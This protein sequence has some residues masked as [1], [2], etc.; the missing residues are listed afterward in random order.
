MQEGQA[1]NV[2]ITLGKLTAKMHEN[3]PARNAIIQ[4][5]DSY[6]F[7]FPTSYVEAYG[8]GWDVVGE[9][10]AMLYSEEP[11]DGD[12]MNTPSSVKEE[13]FIQDPVITNRRYVTLTAPDQPGVTVYHQIRFRLYDYYCGLY[14]IH[15]PRLVFYWPS[16]T[17]GEELYTIRTTPTGD[18]N[19]GIQ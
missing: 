2:T 15:Y 8:I 13:P 9:H 1:T 11:W 18:L 19:I 7:S 10:I 14:G 17:Y 5:G 12:T 16:T 6:T 4:E 3:V